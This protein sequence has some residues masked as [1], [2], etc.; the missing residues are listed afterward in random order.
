MKMEEEEE[1]GEEEEEE[2]WKT[3]SDQAGTAGAGGV[4]GALFTSNK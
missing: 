4:E 2:A 3:S 1:G